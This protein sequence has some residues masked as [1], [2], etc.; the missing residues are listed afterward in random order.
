MMSRVLLLLKKS[1]LILDLLC[2]MF[3]SNIRSMAV[4]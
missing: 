2:F 1:S 3:V 4:G